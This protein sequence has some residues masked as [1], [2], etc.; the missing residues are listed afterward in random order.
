MP[1]GTLDWNLRENNGELSKDR[2]WTLVLLY[3]HSNAHG[4]CWPSIRTLCTEIGC[5]N[6]K[7]DSIIDWLVQRGALMKVPLDKRVTEE[8]ALNKRK[9]VYQLTGVIQIGEQ[10]KHYLGGMNRETQSTLRHL[11]ESL[12]E[13]GN[14]LHDLIFKQLS[15]DNQTINDLKIKSSNRLKIKHKGTTGIEGTKSKVIALNSAKEKSRPA[16]EL[17]PIKDAIVAAFGWK[18][19]AMT[20][21]EK[22]MIQNAAAQLFDAGRKADDIPAIHAYCKR[23]DN[24]TPMVL[25]KHQSEVA[26]RAATPTLSPVSDEPAPKP[27]MYGGYFQP[28]GVVAS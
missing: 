6:A 27:S 25:V 24:I 23:F 4:R 19:E 3:M 13:P 9:S 22:G 1:L 10:W 7:A 20:K 28:K 21:S 26:K 8:K 18:W 14:A 17:N 2:G 12:C 15:F 11:I 16:A 5:A